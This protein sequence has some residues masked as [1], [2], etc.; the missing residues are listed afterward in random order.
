MLILTAASL[1]LVL[2]GAQIAGRGEFHR[3][4]H[5]PGKSGALKGIF[6]LFVFASH[7][8]NYLDLVGWDELAFRPVTYVGQLMVA[9]FLFYSG[10][11]V[12]ESIR[13]KGDPYVRAIPVHRCLRTLAH[14]DIA[15]C[16]FL[17]VRIIIQKE[18]TPG[19]FLLSLLAW[20]SIGNS[21][22]FI[23]AILLLY[24]I[25]TVCFLWLKK[26]LPAAALTTV[27]TVAAMAVLSRF[28][29]E[30]W[31]NTM[32]CYC[33]GM[34]F[35]LLRPRVEKVLMGSEGVYFAVLAVVTGAY[36]ALGH[37]QYRLPFGFYVYGILFMILV[38]IVS[39]KLELNNRFL[40]FLGDHVFEVYIL[41][42]IPMRM[43]RSFRV[44]RSQPVV[45]VLLSFAITCLLAVV[46]R[47]AMDR[48]DRVVFA[49]RS[50]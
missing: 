4:Y 35:S 36:L 21:N 34:W 22:W 46:F 10:F 20:E 28:K 16:L 39:M 23:F 31:Y 44:A 6:V 7:V 27:L 40:R 42:R 24:L 26:P 49:R 29:E 13:R 12:M 41:Q 32:L 15:V 17:L 37:W 2:Y 5:S 19:Q 47:R 3:D 30:H 9:P 14:F 25:T 33:L 18:V 45:F 50:S 8:Y 1:L 43:M 48:L 11:G 38:V